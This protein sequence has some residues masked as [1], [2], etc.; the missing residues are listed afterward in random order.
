MKNA[1]LA[2]LLCRNS[3]G[4]R[5]GCCNNCLTTLQTLVRDRKATWEEL[6]AAKV[7]LPAKRAGGGEWRNYPKRNS[8]R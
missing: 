6:I 2:C 8:K 5:R 3:I 4:I 1:S 7:V